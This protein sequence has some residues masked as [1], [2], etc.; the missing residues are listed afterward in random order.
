[1]SV[2]T[3]TGGNTSCNVDSSPTLNLNPINYG[4]GGIQIG[5]V[6]IAATNIT[7]G[8]CGSTGGTSSSG[9]NLDL[10]LDGLGDSLSG[11]SKLQN[12]GRIM[13]RRQ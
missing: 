2:S 8:G 11:G 4:S 1:M 13:D 3:S 10:K 12:L 6:G 7:N 5:T 9:F